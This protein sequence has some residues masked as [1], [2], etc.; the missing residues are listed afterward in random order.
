[1]VNLNEPPSLLRNDIDGGGNWIKLRLVGTR[2]NR[3]AIGARVVCEYG[4]RLQ[5]QEVMAQSSYYSC[6]DPRLHFGVGDET[7]VALRIR[8]PSGTTQAIDSVTV[9]QIM[10]ISEP[11]EQ[12]QD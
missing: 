11:P 12:A 4:S 8:W 5:A 9:N 2:S 10:T 6:N 3:S 1:M 7:S